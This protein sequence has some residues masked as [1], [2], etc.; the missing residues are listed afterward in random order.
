M[1]QNTLL[2]TKRARLWIPAMYEVKNSKICNFWMFWPVIQLINGIFNFCRILTRCPV[3]G[4]P[5]QTICQSY[6]P[7]YLEVLYLPHA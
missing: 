4:P 7:K 5:D 1:S 2:Y 6:R 3:K